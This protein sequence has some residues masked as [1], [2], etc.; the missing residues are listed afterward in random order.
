M[1]ICFGGIH[2]YNGANLP[3]E[4]MLK[5]VQEKVSHIHTY[6]SIHGMCDEVHN[7]CTKTHDVDTKSMNIN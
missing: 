7:L 1:G 5:R 6:G 3:T 4:E 2:A